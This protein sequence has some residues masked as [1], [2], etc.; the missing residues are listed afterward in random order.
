[1]AAR[2]DAGE[3]GDVNCTRGDHVRY[4]SLMKR[5]LTFDRTY[6]IDTSNKLVGIRVGYLDVGRRCRRTS[7]TRYADAKGLDGV[8]RFDLPRRRRFGPGA[9]VRVRKG[10]LVGLTGVIAEFA[11]NDRLKVLFDFAWSADDDSSARDGDHCRLRPAA[12]AVL[13][14]G[15]P[16]NRGPPI[17]KLCPQSE[18]HRPLR[19][20]GG[21]VLFLNPNQQGLPC[22][23]TTAT[24]SSWRD[25]EASMMR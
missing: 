10:V 22:P 5:S 23:T 14:S 7:S 18:R 20:A 25:V 6:L 2:I 17:A 24:Q 15:V 8:I 13:L 1:M 12:R 4:E 16:P 11:G 9:K 3:S 21:A 19:T